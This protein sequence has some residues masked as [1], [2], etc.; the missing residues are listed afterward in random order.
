MMEWGSDGV[1]SD[2]QWRVKWVKLVKSLN[3]GLIFLSAFRRR[4][5][6]RCAFIRVTGSAILDF[7]SWILDFISAA[8]FSGC[9]GF[10][11]MGF[12]RGL[13]GFDLR[14][15]EH[16]KVVHFFKSVN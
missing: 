13:I 9:S 3:G 14:G 7:R 10:G 11:S 2:A 6:P 5:A 12:K 8:G 1:R 4:Y 15:S 16:A